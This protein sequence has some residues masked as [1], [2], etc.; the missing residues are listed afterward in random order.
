[1]KISEAMGPDNV[2]LDVA[3]SSKPSILK[4]VAGKAGTDLGI[5][6]DEIYDALQNREALGSTGIGSGIAMPHAQINGIAQPFA[7][8][9]RLS[10][11]LDFEAID[12]ELVDVIC[13]I[14]TP[15][16]EQSQ[17]LR[18]LAQFARQLRSSEVLNSI[19]SASEPERIC[20][21]MTNSG[22]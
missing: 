13:L 19:R 8:M 14:L 22:D 21:A 1:M 17:H 9:V 12:E 18:L 16:G 3:A 6:P 5:S 20:E 4:F 2:F 11:P 7:L 10:R 15:V